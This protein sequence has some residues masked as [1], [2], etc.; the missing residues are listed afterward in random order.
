MLSEAL[1]ASSRSLW[2]PSGPRRLV[3]S[4]SDL[5]TRSVICDFGIATGIHF[6]YRTV[7]FDIGF[8]I[9]NLARLEEGGRIVIL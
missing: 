8:K 6:V 9:I 3:L 1:K 5:L 7:A 2:K 4:R